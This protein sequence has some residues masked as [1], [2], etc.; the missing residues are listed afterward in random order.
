MTAAAQTRALRTRRLSLIVAAFAIG[1]SVV[2]TWLHPSDFA[3]AY[4]FALLAW[5]EPAVGSLIFLLIYRCTGGQWGEAL[6][7]FLGAGIRF[8][9]WLWL[10]LLPLIWLAPASRTLD[11]SV[12]G[13]LRIYLSTTALGLRGI[14]YAIVFFVFWWLARPAGETPGHTAWGARLAGFGPVGLIVLAFTL[15]LLAVDWLFALDPGWYSTA[16]PLIWMAGQAMMGLSL[17]V[18]V[19][20]L[21]GFDPKAKGSSHRA[22]GLDWGNLLLTCTIFWAY[23]SFMQFL[24]IWSGNIAQEVTWYVHRSHGLWLVIVVGLALGNLALPFFLLLSR[25]LK[26]RA[27]SLGGIAALLLFCQFV[28]TAWL[29]LPSYPGA[30]LLTYALD[31]ALL[32]AAGGLF[33]N[34]YLAV[35]AALSPSRP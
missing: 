18:L 9:P 34:R 5:F 1:T 20:L 7:P 33:F 27:R 12:Q 14:V 15:H 21:F 23:V 31:F 32:A 30:T 28:Y 25:D 35:A 11:P 26:Q 8:L 2:L 29:I 3:G 16:F 4:R 19:A 6:Q 13:S 24:I 10:L 17:A 22:L